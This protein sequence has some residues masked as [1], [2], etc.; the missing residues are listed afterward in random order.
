MSV[1]K[2]YLLY[3][4]VLFGCFCWIVT[5]IWRLIQFGCVVYLILVVTNK[6]ISSFMI[7]LDTCSNGLAAHSSAT[8]SLIWEGDQTMVGT[9]QE[10]QQK[11]PNAVTLDSFA[12]PVRV[13]GIS[14]EWYNMAVSHTKGHKGNTPY[15]FGKQQFAHNMGIYLGTH[16]GMTICQQQQLCGHSG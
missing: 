11:S 5:N 13:C 6:G 15:S 3:R 16:P 1:L 4:N 2:T 9:V 7:L 8:L 14:I 10:W 12:E